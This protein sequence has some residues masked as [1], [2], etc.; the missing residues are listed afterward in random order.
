MSMKALHLI[1]ICLF[2]S[3]VTEAATVETVKVFSKSMNKEIPVVIVAPEK[4]EKPLRTVYLLHGYGGNANMWLGIKPNLPDIAERDGLLFVCPDGHNSWYWDS[5]KDPSSRY[6]TFVS[7]ELIEYIDT[8]YPTL[9]AK[10]GR[11]ITGL[12]MGGH[13]ALWIAFRHTET[14]GAAG[15]SSGG[16]DIRPFPKNWEMDKQLGSL[17]ENRELWDSHTVINQIDKIKNGDLALI[18]D[19]GYGD[20]FFEVNN[21]FHAKLLENAINHDY[22]VRPGVHN[23]PYWKNS[24]D[25]QILFFLKYFQMN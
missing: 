6:E 2:F 5:P 4:S 8:H 12:S 21:N 20:F 17:E 16:V 23:G 18:V 10:E 25:Y 1:F 9:P 14:F 11:A 15:S 24:I 22:I 3:I 7:Q 13:G 19:C